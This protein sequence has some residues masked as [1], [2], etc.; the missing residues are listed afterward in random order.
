MPNIIFNIL[1]YF[2]GITIYKY[3]QLSHKLTAT[4]SVALSVKRWAT[5]PGSRVQF[6]VGGLGVAFFATSPGWVLICISV[7][8][9]RFY[10]TLKTIY[11]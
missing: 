4:A 8:D 5:V 6:P 1:L 7:S 10:H 11:T 2:T 3:T 9:T